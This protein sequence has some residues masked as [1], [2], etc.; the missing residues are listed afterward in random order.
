[1]RI[2]HILVQLIRSRAKDGLIRYMILCDCDLHETNSLGNTPL[3]ESIKRSRHDITTLL[4]NRGA[5]VHH[6]DT[7]MY[8]DNAL[9]WAV[10][11]GNEPL[12]RTLINMGCDVNT[13]TTHHGN[14]LLVWAQ[15][16]Q[17]Y[18][19][20]CLLLDRGADPTLCTNEGR[21]VFSMCTLAVY[22]DRLEEWK[23]QMAL[24]VDAFMERW[25]KGKRFERYV[26][27]IILDYLV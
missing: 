9:S 2:P 10:F 26:N 23:D 25:G 24:A 15:N 19:I 5:N 13:R 21:T 11:L 4:L 7:S 17:H 14:S 18:S 20:F 12:A 27:N 6:R 3:I 8:Q 1:M 22:Y 16:K